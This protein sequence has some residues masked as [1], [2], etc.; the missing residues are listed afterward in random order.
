MRIIII[1]MVVV[2]VIVVIIVIIFDI[3][4]YSSRMLPPP[5][6]LVW[7]WFGGPSR[8]S[9]RI[10]K[11]IFP[12]PTLRTASTQLRPSCN[13]VRPTSVTEPQENWGSHR[14]HHLVCVEMITQMWIRNQ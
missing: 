4:M 7:G 5:S 14:L 8:A 13:T 1:L 12:P 10:K 3:K 9:L 11:A 6:G 2:I